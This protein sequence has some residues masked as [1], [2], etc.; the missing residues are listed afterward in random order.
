[1]QD[2]DFLHSGLSLYYLGSIHTWWRGTL[3]KYGNYLALKFSSTRARICVLC[4]WK[5][6]YS[7]IKVGTGSLCAHAALILLLL[8][9][10]TALDSLLS[11]CST[12]GSD[13][14][15]WSNYVHRVTF[16]MHTQSVD[17]EP[18]CTGTHW[19][20]LVPGHEMWTA[21]YSPKFYTIIIF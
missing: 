6:L 5:T 16:R 13:R 1:M 11:S 14:A 2:A 3:P 21:P 12:M 15:K 10:S 18:F 9:Q 8:G 19:C 20:S 17:P 7:G 4:Q